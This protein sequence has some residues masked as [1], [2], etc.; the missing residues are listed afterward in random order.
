LKINV[1]STKFDDYKAETIHK[2]FRNNIR[3]K[4]FKLAQPDSIIQTFII[5]SNSIYYLSRL[6]RDNQQYLL[7]AELLTPT[8][9]VSSMS[10]QQQQ[11]QQQQQVTILDRDEI[12]FQTDRLFKQLVINFDLNIKKHSSSSSSSS[13]SFSG[14]YFDANGQQYQTIYFTLPLFLII[15]TIVYFRFKDLNEIFKI[16][17]QK[18]DS[19]L[20]SAV[21]VKSNIQKSNQQQQQKIPKQ[22]LQQMHFS[23]KSSNELDTSS[24]SSI[25]VID[26]EGNSISPKKVRV[27][28]T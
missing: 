25:D 27:R 15:L 20:G 19:S 11:Q 9:L 6:P 13:S 2:S 10:A 3:I 24:T 7:Q 17:K 23:D 18:I 5:P 16:I 26:N 21:E 14:T 28:K 8:A 1:I 12:I 4:L 22:Q